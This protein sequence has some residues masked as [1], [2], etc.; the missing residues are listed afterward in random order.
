MLKNKTLNSTKKYQLGILQQSSC[1]NADI[2]NKQFSQEND[3]VTFHCYIIEIVRKDKYVDGKLFS[4]KKGLIN[5]ECFGIITQED[6]GVIPSFKLLNP[7]VIN[8]K[9]FNIEYVDIKYHKKRRIKKQSFKCFLTFHQKLFDD[10]YLRKD[11]PIVDISR[12]F[13]G[14]NDE[15]RYLIT[16]IFRSKGGWDFV[17]I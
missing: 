3:I 16:P 5:E 9:A 6:F 4:S 13:I 11:S 8:E 17:R 10:L 2:L 1:I 12:L 7:L 14:D 15:R